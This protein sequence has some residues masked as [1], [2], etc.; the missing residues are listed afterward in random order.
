MTYLL[1]AKGSQPGPVQFHEVVRHT[2]GRARDVILNLES[3]DG[4][5][6]AEAG[7]AELVDEFGEECTTKMP[8][9]TFFAR[10]QRSEESAI[11]FAIAL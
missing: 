6:R 3:R 5:V 1:T 11:D 9:A 8:I 7:I 10:K 4:E 2:R